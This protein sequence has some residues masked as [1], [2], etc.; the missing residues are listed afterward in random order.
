MVGAMTEAERT[1]ELPRFGTCTYRESEVLTFPWGLPG[2]PAS[3]RFLA[4][5]VADQGGVFWLQSLDEPKVALPVVDPYAFFPDYDPRLPAFA[6]I[7]LELERAEDFALLAVAIIPEEGDATLNLLAPIVINLRTQ[8][9][10]QVTVEGGDYPMRAPLPL[11]RGGQ[12]APTA[13]A[14]AE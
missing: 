10:R 9:G 6:R 14:A 4:L 13:E 2:F 1:I 5:S 11:V 7:S 8:I 3:Q 12:P